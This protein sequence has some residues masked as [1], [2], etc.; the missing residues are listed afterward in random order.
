[1]RAR[2]RQRRSHS[3]RL[4]AGC[5]ES[6]PAQPST[7]RR[8][9]APQWTVSPCAP[10]ETPGELPIAFRVAAGAAPPGPL[11]DGAAAGI[12]TG[13]TVPVGAD[14][15][16]P[17]EV[18]EDR[19]ERLFVPAAAS[20]GQHIRPR[21]GDVGAGAIVVEPGTSLGPVQIGALAASG[22]AVVTCSTRPR[23]AILATG[24]EL[25]NPGEELEPG[26][27]YESNRRMV[28]AAL[29]GSGAEIDVLPVAADDRGFPSGRDRTWSGG[30][31]SR[32]LGRGL[33]GAARPRPS[34]RR[35][36]RG[37]GGLLGRR[38]QAGQAAGVR[39]SGRDARLR[40]PREPCL[41]ARR[42]AAVRPPRAPRTPGSRAAAAG[43]PV[44]R[45]SVRGGARNP[46]RDEFVRARRLESDR[47]CSPRGG[48]RPGVA[49][50]RSRRCG[51]CAR[52]RAPR[53][54]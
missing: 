28:A 35:R 54:G 26:Q 42:G 20:T 52:A 40:T 47:R 2:S 1:M 51:R 22:V 5:F 18:V 9:R 19:G 39:R 8:S 38:R 13:G 36:A 23:V 15:V 4:S 30:G 7:C 21:G 14:T 33:D 44:R 25:R 37:R 10:R 3:T 31:R 41:V 24:D 49:H 32:H 12:A 16:V 50:D 34:R 43:L 17:V 27:I 6:L 53:R 48:H 11:P 46:H 45:A 29:A